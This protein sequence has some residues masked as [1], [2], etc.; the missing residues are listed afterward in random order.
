MA[1]RPLFA[2]GKQGIDVTRQR[3]FGRPDA[4][5]VND[6]RVV[7]GLQDARHGFARHTD[8]ARN[9]MQAQPR[10]IDENANNVLRQRSSQRSEG[11]QIMLGNFVGEQGQ[12]VSHVLAANPSAPT[13]HE[14]VMRQVAPR[15]ARHA[16]QRS[17]VNAGVAL[18]CVVESL[19]PIQWAA[20]VLKD[21]CTRTTHEASTTPVVIGLGAAPT[22]D[23]M[24]PMT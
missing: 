5:S 10:F 12:P 14:D 17:F 9:G 18:N 1:I 6:A 8:A 24:E 21:A 3:I 22:R 15:F 11:S 19:A 4:A 20:E 2:I 7:Q 23:S 16:L 13:Q